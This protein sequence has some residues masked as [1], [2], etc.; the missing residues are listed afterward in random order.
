MPLESWMRQLGSI[1]EHRLF[2][3]EL[4]PRSEENYMLSNEE[5]KYI[6]IMLTMPMQPKHRNPI[7][8]NHVLNHVFVHDLIGLKLAKIGEGGFSNIYR[9]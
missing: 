7:E 3:N 6:R 1:Y 5:M 2:F 4:V 9:T 8:N